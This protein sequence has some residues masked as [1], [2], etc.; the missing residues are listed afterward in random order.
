MVNIMGWG[1][2]FGQREVFI[3]E[4]GK[5]AENMEMA[6]LWEVVALFMR[7]SGKM[8]DIMARED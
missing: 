8:G 6:N 5:I 1:N 2:S 3:E 4:N 7:E